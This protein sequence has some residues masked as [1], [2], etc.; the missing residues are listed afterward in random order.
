M[1]PGQRVVAY[2]TLIGRIEP[3][4]GHVH[5]SEMHGG[6]YV[7][8]LRPGGM[9]PYVDRTCPSA[10]QIRFE[11]AGIE[12]KTRAVRG[13]VDLVVGA[14]DPPALSAPAPWKDMPVTPTLIRWRILTEAGRAVRRWQTAVDTRQPHPPERQLR[15]GLRHPHQAK[16]GRTGPGRTA[17]TSRA[18]GTALR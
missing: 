10:K 17:S 4:W 15:D 12:T 6:A 7:N 13:V 16:L 9:G 8:P 5:L 14:W 1:R 11:R 2:R 18:A 3:G